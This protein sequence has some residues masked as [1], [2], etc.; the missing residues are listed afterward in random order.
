MMKRLMA[1]FA[2][3]AC[4]CLAPMFDAEAGAVSGQ[5]AKTL[6]GK[7]MAIELGEKMGLPSEDLEIMLYEYSNF[8]KEMNELREGRAKAKQAL[9][10]AVEAGKGDND[11]LDLLEDLMELDEEIAAL[12][13][14]Y[15]EAY[16]AD[17]SGAQLAH[18][19]L[20]LAD[21]DQNIAALMC[22]ALCDAR[23][24]APASATCGVPAA[25]AVCEE[26]A[27]SVSPEDAA[28]AAAKAWGEAL[29]GQD[30]DNI[31][32]AFA[33]DFEHYEYGDKQGIGD[34]IGQAIDMGYLEDL[35]VY[36]DDAEVEIDGEE[37]IVYPVE[38]MGA[39]GSVTF[40]LVFE[41]RDGKMLI[42]TLDASGI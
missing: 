5:E 35:E 6:I 24:C 21:L 38:L 29:A 8:M 15:T 32:A 16:M 41:Q 10:A 37:L 18:V 26:A 31:L 14:S 17:L 7:A 20:F 3:V 42:T 9:K 1:V 36:L 30:M 13:I 34:F 40:E 2:V 39:F 33:D 12:P 25:Q 4:L 22:A 27:P 11:V 19:Y 23:G 28:L